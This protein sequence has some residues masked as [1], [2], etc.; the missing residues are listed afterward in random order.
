[1]AIK[2]LNHIESLIKRYIII[3]LLF[4]FFNP[5]HA[6][7]SNARKDLS[8]EFI[9][10]KVEKVKGSRSYYILTISRADSTFLVYSERRKKLSCGKR[11]RAGN[12]I[13]MTLE[14]KIVLDETYFIFHPN[15]SYYIE[16]KYK[17]ELSKQAHYQIY[18]AKN[19]NGNCLSK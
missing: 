16:G 10:Q 14:P 18:H 1:M 11:V 8:G 5:C 7:V 4:L 6:Q 2:F 9:I 12:H 17:V 15:T 13:F 19:L 3:S